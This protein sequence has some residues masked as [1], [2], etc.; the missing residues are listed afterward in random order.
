MPISVK[1]LDANKRQLDI[2]VGADIV[3]KKFDDVYERIAREAKIPGFR[4]GKAPRHILEKHHSKFAYEEVLKEMIPETYQSAI[5]KENIDVIA[6]PQISDVQ[7]NPA[8]L[9]FRATVETRPGV[10]I[11]DYKKIKIKYKKAAVTAE[12]LNSALDAL[13]K[14]RKA[15]SLDDNL[16]RDLGYADFLE[17]KD[18]LDKQ[19][20]MKKQQE[21]RLHREKL[22]VEYL[23]SNSSLVVPTSLVNYR[24]EELVKEAK[25]Q[26]S[27]R[28]MPDEEVDKK[29]EELR[30]ELA[31][32]AQTQV[33]LSLILD[34]I[35]KREN[36]PIDNHTA[37]KVIEFLLREADWQ[38]A[39]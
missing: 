9:K 1:K 21:E 36:I 8:G 20:L 30:K 3:K 16:A 19:I 39:S 25:T 37:G 34:E 28:G 13:K 14:A 7:L 11:K 24:L 4:P 26:L 2:D 5:E 31:N 18:V 38:E 32:E 22:L 33:K 6:L 35:A 10:E 15:E 23:L 12:D 27:M 29:E 17:L